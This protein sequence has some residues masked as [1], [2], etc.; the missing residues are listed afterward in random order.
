[1]A[2]LEHWTTKGVHPNLIMVLN[3][4]L[5]SRAISQ[6]RDTAKLAKQTEK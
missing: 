5:T 1:M 6:Q 2:A 4:A 3:L